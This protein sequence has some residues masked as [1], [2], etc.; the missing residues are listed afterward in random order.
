MSAT[1]GG[2]GQAT[3]AHLTGKNCCENTYLIL[4]CEPSWKR[5]PLERCCL[6][7]PPISTGRSAGIS[8]AALATAVLAFCV[9]VPV[10]GAIRAKTFFNDE[11]FMEL[12]LQEEDGGLPLSVMLLRHLYFVFLLLWL[13][14]GGSAC[15]ML[16]SLARGDTDRPATC[17]GCCI[18][19]GMPP[20]LALSKL[21][22]IAAYLFAIAFFVSQFHSSQI[23]LSYLD[24]DANS[25]LCQCNATGSYQLAE[26]PNGGSCAAKSYFICE[27][28]E[29]TRGEA[30]GSAVSEDRA[31][32]IQQCAACGLDPRCV[33]TGLALTR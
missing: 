33:P 9:M 22:R 11:S 30:V 28:P 20:P 13:M 26:L 16:R 32:L 2:A 19:L 25:R 12:F 5:K 8:I 3:G 6:C 24:P 23:C 21:L 18:S 31:Q 29:D 15:I 14:I 10:I 27:A 1:G 17:G 7:G 4:A